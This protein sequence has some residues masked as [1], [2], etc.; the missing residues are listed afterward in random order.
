MSVHHARAVE[1]AKIAIRR[2]NH[3]RVRKLARAIVEAQEREVE[4]FRAR[5]ARRP[6][7]SRTQVLR[8]RQP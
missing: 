8:L 1:R 5:A 4:Q 7:P 3:P 2:A 6:P